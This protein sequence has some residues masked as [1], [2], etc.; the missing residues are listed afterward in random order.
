MI[1]QL[2]RPGSNTSFISE[3]GK[4]PLQTDPLAWWGT[5]GAH[6]FTSFQPGLLFPHFL[7]YDPF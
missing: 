2:Y 3:D 4:I 5:C 7:G 6:F 1:S